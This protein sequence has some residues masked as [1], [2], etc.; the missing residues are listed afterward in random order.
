MINVINS[1]LFAASAYA[2]RISIDETKEFATDVAQVDFTRT[3]LIDKASSRRLGDRRMGE[4]ADL[5]SQFRV[6]ELYTQINFGGEIV[7]VTPLEYDDII[8]WF[9]NR[10]DGVKGY[11]TVNSVTGESTLTRLTEGNGMRYMPSAYLFDNLDRKLRFAY[12]TTM[13]DRPLFEIDDEGRPYWIVP[14]IKYVGIGLRKEITG[15]VILDPATG[16]SNKYKVG[17]IPEWVDHVW[18]ADLL[19]T[20]VNHWGMFQG[21]FWNSIFGQRNVVNTTE[22]YNYL[23]LNDDIY[24][25]SGIT[26]ASSDQSILG[27]VLINM[28]TK[29]ANYYAV[30]GAKE[31]SAMASAQ[32]QVQQM[33]YIATFPL[34]INLNGNPTYLMSLK[35]NAGLVKMYAFVDVVDYQ[36]VVV[37]DISLGI[38]T[39]ARR[40]I[41]ETGIP[42]VAG[43]REET[44][45][46]IRSITEAVIDGS[47]YYFIT[48][49]NNNRYIVSVK[50]DRYRLPFL[51]TGDKITVI[52]HEDQE[53]RIITEL[54]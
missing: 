48:D 26:S 22:G 12:P 18:E 36:R 41:S 3:P 50:I 19:L 7:R 11:I 52:Y 8:K 35:D 27:F 2:R 16:E 20:Q 30:P 4:M 5:V 31:Y 10:K 39:A 15:V 13:F 21:G 46:E 45:I 25:Y 29:A 33:E 28:R 14:T 9:T 38:E 24:M 49:R 37:T 32:G 51:K 43:N 47:T 44:T 23:A 34:L 6:S 53:I 17:D 1:P 40:F 54:R 42:G